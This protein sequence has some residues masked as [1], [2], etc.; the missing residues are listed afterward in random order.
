MGGVEPHMAISPGRGPD[1]HARDER[2]RDEF[3]GHPP[4]AAIWLPDHERDEARC[5]PC[6]VTERQHLARGQVHGHAR[7]ALP[8]IWAS[9]A[10]ERAQLAEEESRAE[11]AS[12]WVRRHRVQRRLFCRISHFKIPVQIACPCAAAA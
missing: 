2:I 6:H 11:R 5:E 12:T 7:Q 1:R 3:R 9:V 10:R 8:W 4:V